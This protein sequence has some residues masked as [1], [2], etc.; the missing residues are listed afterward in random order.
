[1]THPAPPP[2][3][4][5]QETSTPRDDAESLENTPNTSNS[6]GVGHAQSGLDEDV[7][8][9]TKD[10]HC[11]QVGAAIPLG[12]GPLPAVPAHDPPSPDGLRSTGHLARATHVLQ[13]VLGKNGL[14]AGDAAVYEGL[15]GLARAVRAISAWIPD[16]SEWQDLAAHLEAQAAAREQLLGAYSSGIA[17]GHHHPLYG[18]FGEFPLY[19]GLV[20]GQ[21]IPESRA[22]ASL[23]GLACWPH[24]DAV[25]HGKPTPPIPEVVARGIYPLLRKAATCT[26]THRWLEALF[27]TAD[28]PGSLLPTI[29]LLPQTERNKER[30]KGIRVLAE[31]FI[32]GM[33]RLHA[34]QDVDEDEG[35]DDQVVSSGIT[36]VVEPHSS[37]DSTTDGLAPSDRGH[38]DTFLAVD[39][40]KDPAWIR[41]RTI[42]A[43]RDHNQLHLRWESLTE[44][45]IDYVAAIYPTLLKDSATRDGA[46]GLALLAAV[47]L[48]LDRLARLRLA[49]SVDDDAALSSTGSAT[50]VRLEDRLVAMVAVAKPDN[51][52]TQDGAHYLPVASRFFLALPTSCAM[53]LDEAGWLPG[54]T[55]TRRFPTLA[56]DVR[57]LLAK[58]RAETGHRLTP[59]RLRDAVAKEIYTRTQDECLAS[60]VYPAT[61]IPVGAGRFYLSLTCQEAADLQFPA[62]Q[63]LFPGDVE[64][65]RLPGTV[66]EL[67]IGSELVVAPQAIAQAIDTLWKRLCLQ[68]STGRRSVANVANALNAH[69]MW[70]AALTRLVAF[71][72]PVVDPL[73]RPA[74]FDPARGFAVVCDKRESPRNEQRLV[75]L[76]KPLTEQVFLTRESHEAAALF[77]DRHAP[78]LASGLRS[79]SAE[80]MGCASI[81]ALPILE[82]LEGQWRFREFRPED[83]AWPEFAWAANVGRHL[84]VRAGRQKHLSREI[85]SLLLGHAEIGQTPYGWDSVLTPEAVQAITQPLLDELASSYGIQ[86]LPALS[87]HSLGTEKCA[88]EFLRAPIF[89]DSRP[90]RNAHRRLTDSEKSH[91]KK[92][93]LAPSVLTASTRDAALLAMKRELG[94]ALRGSPAE[95]KWLHSLAERYLRFHWR[96][97]GDSSRNAGVKIPLEAETGPIQRAELLLADRGRRAREQLLRLIENFLADNPER[98]P[99]SE[100]M[101][102]IG[103]NAVAFGGCL[104][105]KGLE[106]IA[107]ACLS[108]LRHHQGTILLD[109]TTERGEF[110]FVPDALT[111]SL[112]LKWHDTR[113]NATGDLDLPAFRK[114]ASAFLSRIDALGDAPYAWPPSATRETRMRLAIGALLRQSVPGVLMAHML[115]VRRS[116]P[117]PISCLQRELGFRLDSPAEPARHESALR[118]KATCSRKDGASDAIKALQK[119]IGKIRASGTLGGKSKGT[120]GERLARLEQD[121]AEIE[122]SLTA[123]VEQPDTAAITHMVIARLRQLLRKGG[124]LKQILATSTIAEYMAPVLRFAATELG[125]SM[126][127]ADPSALAAAY[128]NI[129][130]SGAASTASVRYR[131]LEDF[132]CL[133]VEQFGVE[134]LDWSEIAED[135]PGVI[136]RVDANLIHPHEVNLALALIDGCATVPS[137]I[138]LRTKLAIA[139]MAD[140]G[141]RFGEAYR[142][143]HQDISP[144]RRFAFVRNTRDGEVK[145]VNGVRILPIGALCSDRTRN[146]LDE[147][148]ALTDPDGTLRGEAALFGGLQNPR[149]LIPRSL[150]A[151]LANQAIRAA[152]GDPATRLHHLRHGAATALL[153]RIVLPTDRNLQHDLLTEIVGT[154]TRTR[155]AMWSLAMLMGHGSGRTTAVSYVHHQER[156]VADAMNR[157]LPRLGDSLISRLI[158]QTASAVR[159]YRSRGKSDGEILLHHIRHALAR[160]PERAVTWG[161]QQPKTPPVLDTGWIKTYERDS[162]PQI[163]HALRLY[164]RG[165]LDAAATGN[166]TGIAASDIEQLAVTAQRLA[167]EMRLPV[168]TQG[169]PACFLAPRSRLAAEGSAAQ[170]V[171]A[172]G[173]SDEA[174]QLAAE[175]IKAYD[176]GR[177][178]WC[179]RDG[180]TLRNILAWLTLAGVRNQNIL[181]RVPESLWDEANALLTRSTSDAPATLPVEGRA[182]RTRGRDRYMISVVSTRG[183]D[184]NHASFL[185]LVRWSTAR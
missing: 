114:A 172:I 155:R 176:H 3:D 88:P 112:L 161:L 86:L 7:E 75:P 111:A 9:G 36:K 20:A 60:L 163:D 149:D 136:V 157:G 71:V 91:I 11:W 26:S 148:I 78:D 101:A 137:D 169:N 70:I 42:A 150:I 41:A 158:G 98:H 45:E 153:D 53:A 139:M 77:F 38:P 100:W 138:R 180:H 146:L 102:L 162:L 174:K 13:S 72:R 79:L 31:Q 87:P 21:Q 40:L 64:Q 159:S 92:A 103:L 173:R 141:L 134:D 4:P 119:R 145:T 167:A 143:P 50:I 66:A 15:Y 2:T 181:V 108:G 94:D 1:M 154:T 168:D 29:D 131:S 51:A 33:A 96:P 144:S 6:A 133:A 115:A 160:T 25:L 151:R 62:L 47:G 39:G 34:R 156:R 58:L 44:E 126:L 52:A 175:A 182:K 76:A 166:V 54:E 109:W 121:I 82:R 59:G 61:R 22:W 129:I 69:S 80:G 105:S 116:T 170:A 46:V 32:A 35:D 90:G 19:S 37:V 93:S 65:L 142:L 164:F 130:L 28:Q 122:A 184:L 57:T 17:P 27:E 117:V 30:A 16:A 147:A 179:C 24:V 67:Y 5:R 128:R 83:L 135:V 8:I 123:L 23:A 18:D 183:T 49:E 178:A 95:R 132:H 74:D 56:S 106:A 99:E 55:I 104:Q 177:F 140:L 110:R 185:Q 171:A 89:G 84:G 68:V 120:R 85:M 14:P 127:T 63:R 152:T 12:H 48:P 97:Q 118:I 125:R 107:K 10:E 81:P 43:A 73:P 113:A 124:R 165:G